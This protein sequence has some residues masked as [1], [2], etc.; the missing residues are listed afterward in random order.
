MMM[1]L[2]SKKIKN[3]ILINIEYKNGKITSNG[4]P[5]IQ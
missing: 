5:I 1:N 4:K 3:K 2:I